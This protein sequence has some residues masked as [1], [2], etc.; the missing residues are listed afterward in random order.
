MIGLK[1][2]NV[3]SIISRHFSSVLSGFLRK[4]KSRT[5]HG[6]TTDKRPKTSEMRN[7]T[8][9]KIKL[10]CNLNDFDMVL[11]FDLKKVGTK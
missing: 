5:L 1:I 3:V 11:E 7:M 2:T 4:K 9:K 8:L 6:E 10:I